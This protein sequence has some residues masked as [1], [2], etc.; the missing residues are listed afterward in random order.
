MAQQFVA[1]LLAESTLAVCRD[2]PEELSEQTVD[3]SPAQYKSGYISEGD[4]LK[5]KLQLL[6]FQT[7]VSSAKLARVQALVGLR[8]LLGYD[9]VPANYD[10]VGDLAYEPVPCKLEDL[11]AEGLAGASRLSRCRTWA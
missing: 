1:V 11:Q 2:G 10:V 8:E 7:D 6:Q 3:I 5:I 4:Y 9:A